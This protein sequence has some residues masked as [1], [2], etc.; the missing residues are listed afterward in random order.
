MF[1]RFE[2]R[3]AHDRCTVLTGEISPAEA[4]L[5]TLAT[6]SL[7]END[8]RTRDRCATPS[9]EPIIDVD[10]SASTV[11]ISTADG[12]RVVHVSGELDIVSRNLVSRAC[13]AGGDNTV[14]VEMASVT[15]M[16]CCGYGGL[17]A[18]RR[19]LEDNG[20][21]LTLLNQAGQPARL[22]TLLSALGAST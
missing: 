8:V 13:L 3:R 6:P 2:L 16:D 4:L 7:Q 10:V 18:A 15:F 22:L 11:S 9:P 21:S 1:R 12:C 14:V 17:V 19:I 20:G 5:K